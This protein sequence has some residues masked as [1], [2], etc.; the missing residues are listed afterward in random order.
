[1]ERI[2]TDNTT[3]TVGSVFI[4]SLELPTPVVSGSG[5]ATSHSTG[6]LI[7]SLIEFSAFLLE[8]KL[9]R[10][11]YETL[12]HGNGD[13]CSI[14][15]MIHSQI[16]SIFVGGPKPGVRAG[17]ANPRR[18]VHS[19]CPY[20]LD[21]L[22]SQTQDWPA[23][24]KIIR[25]HPR[26]PR[27]LA[28]RIPPRWNHVC[29]G[30]TRASR[31]VRTRP[32][33]KKKGHVDSEYLTWRPFGDSR[34]RTDSTAISD[35]DSSIQ[36]IKEEREVLREKE[37]EEREAGEIARQRSFGKRMQSFYRP[38]FD[39]EFETLIE[40]IHPPWICIDNDSCGDCTLVKVDS[41]NK[42]G[43]LLDM[44]QVLTDLDLVISK[45]YIS[46]DGGWF[47]DVFHVTDRR[48]NKITEQSVIH[49][50]QQALCA[51]RKSG[52]GVSGPQEEK[53]HQG[54]LVGPSQVSA[55]NTAL[56]MT[57]VDRPGLLSELSAVLAE[58][59]CDIVVAE[60]W[61]HNKRAACIMYLRDQ[62]TG[63]PISDRGRLDR[64][65][66]QL[67]NVLGAHCQCGGDET[68]RMRVRLSGPTPGRPHTERR[69]HQLMMAD[70]DYE[71]NEEGGVKR[72]RSGA[73]VSIENCKEKGYSIVNV[74]SKDRPKLLFDTVCT[75]TDM[76][77]VVFHAAISSDGP[78][79]AQE[80]YI[81]QTDGCT[82]DSESERQRIAQCLIAAVERRVSH[83]LRL[84]V[85]T[86]NRVGLLS[87]VTRVFRENGLTISRAELSVRGER[88]T[89]AFH[90]VGASGNDVDPN[91]VEM[92][93]KEI[94]ATSLEVNNAPVW[95]VPVRGN[96]A[97]MESSPE[98]KP[99]LSFGSLLRAQ[100]ERIS[101]NFTSIR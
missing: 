26:G 2:N 101:S 84:D 85:C 14:I 36:Y 80:Y 69:L 92:V 43:I 12:F 24:G 97:H 90:V 10:S 73:R 50:I 52:S 16:N 59:E 54:T 34:C 1:M 68:S 9:I 63:R 78:Y 95:G 48:G 3:M 93:R 13:Y 35:L 22:K 60:A 76:N 88:A 87:D 74:K 75:L 46:S 62:A 27:P 49:Y 29:C 44:V 65:E 33:T 28:A 25:E 96:T 41:A 79:A 8:E 17:F 57:A 38:Y 51:G 91:T 83:D 45:S 89:G 61:T 81:R 5:I 67:V 86:R 7:L 66:K 64:I 82:L 53:T 94:G 100:L 6:V 77:Y 4:K 23:P 42:P 31:R 47:M 11:D 32:R 56:E 39:P 98:D 19:V 58:L 18:G 15:T 99:R 30:K 72:K 55:E 37:A 21:S 20:Q 70:R 40:R 71:G